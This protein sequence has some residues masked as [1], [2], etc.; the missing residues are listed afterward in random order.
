M[1][2]LWQI[3]T[4]DHGEGEDRLVVRLD[5]VNPCARCLSGEGC[6]AGVFSRWFAR[7]AVLLPVPE[8]TDFH[9]GQR[10]RVGVN[11]VGLMRA[12]LWVYGLPAVA[13]VGAAILGHRLADGPLLQDLTALF[14]GLAAGAGAFSLARIRPL[15]DM[16][17]V[18]EPVSC[19]AL[20]SERV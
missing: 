15:A 14:L 1:S 16:T 11:A 7:G 2:R 20:E 5:S 12:A 19:A 10:V 17:P 8:D 13:F 9:I 6:G 18:I 4:I 3:G